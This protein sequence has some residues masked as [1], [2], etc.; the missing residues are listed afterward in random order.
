MAEEYRAYETLLR[1]AEEGTQPVL[2][3]LLEL[4]RKIDARFGLVEDVSGSVADYERA[5]REQ[6]EAILAGALSP[7]LATIQG[8]IA[9]LG[10]VFSARSVT[11]FAA[12]RRRRVTLTIDAVDAARFAPAADLAIV[13]AADASSATSPGNSPTTA[14]SASCASP[15]SSAGGVP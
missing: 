4:V 11:P 15:S 10:I 9:D 3:V 7:A 8:A 14:R 13:A 6:G 2:D 5:L 12:G 1:R